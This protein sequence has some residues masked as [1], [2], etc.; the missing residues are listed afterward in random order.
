[1]SDRN[2]KFA[3]Q[4]ALARPTTRHLVSSM[5]LDAWPNHAA[6][7]DFGIDNQKHYEAL[8]FPISQSAKGKSRR[9]HWMRPSA[10]VNC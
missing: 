4:L 6:V 1:M 9:R 5:L 7:V 3:E 10:T 2:P 8:Y